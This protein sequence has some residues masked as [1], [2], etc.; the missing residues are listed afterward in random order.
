MIKA[1]VRQLNFGKKINQRF[2]L[3]E[4]VIEFSRSKIAVLALL[5]L[6]IILFIAACASVI[7]PQ[8][9]YDLAQLDILDG[10]L[11]PGSTGS[12]GMTYWLGTD[13]QGRDMVSA[14]FYGLRTS[15]VVGVMSG[16]I[17]LLIGTCVGLF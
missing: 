13:D 15:L 10:G 8:N 12:S 7:S 3:D 9:P 4:F 11:P 6:L 16:L 14:I 2:G 17:A 5:I 1:L